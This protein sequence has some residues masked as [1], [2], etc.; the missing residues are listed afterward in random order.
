MPFLYFTT[1][2]FSDTLKTDQ[3]AK[4]VYTGMRK[5][6]DMGIEAV[7]KQTLRRLP[8]YLSYLRTLP[9]DRPSNISATMIAEELGLNQVQVRKDLALVSSGG[10]PKIGYITEDL[11]N[12]IESFLGYDGTTD[13][14][15]VGAGKLGQALLSYEGFERY[16]LNIVAAF[17][18]DESVIGSELFGKTVLPVERLEEI[19]KRLQIRIGI[20]TVPGKQAQEICNR[21]VYGGVLAIWNFAP[22]HLTVPPG[23]LVQNENMAASLAVLSKHLAENLSKRALDQTIA[24]NNHEDGRKVV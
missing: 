8:V 4:Q 21:L 6:N 20:I 5:E 11:I 17:D 14:I 7:S 19:C 3:G 12:D 2:A 10:R 23:I 9:K 24:I 22:V 15:L 13:A 18:E 16:A 1:L